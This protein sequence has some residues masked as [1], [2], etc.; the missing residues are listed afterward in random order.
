[1]HN[2]RTWENTLT[3]ENI[4]IAESKIFTNSDNLQ[5]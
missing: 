5:T 4:I 3:R 1:M 2:T